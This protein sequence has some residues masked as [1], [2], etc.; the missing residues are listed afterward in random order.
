MNIRYMHV[1]WVRRTE[2]MLLGWLWVKGWTEA[3]KLWASQKEL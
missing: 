1:Q 2:S 3:G